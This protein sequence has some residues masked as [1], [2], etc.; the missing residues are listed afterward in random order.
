MEGIPR[1]QPTSLLQYH[2]TPAVRY[3]KTRRN[4]D[5]PRVQDVRSTPVGRRIRPCLQ[6]GL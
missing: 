4:K 6:A 5:S 1:V 2:G 3:V